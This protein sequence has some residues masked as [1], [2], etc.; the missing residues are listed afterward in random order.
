VGHSL[1]EC[2]TSDVFQNFQSHILII[3]NF[4]S[5]ILIIYNFDSY[6]Y[7]LLILVNGGIC[8]SR[9]AIELYQEKCNVN[10]V[11]PHNAVAS[12][13]LTDCHQVFFFNK[14]ALVY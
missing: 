7:N 11:I 14:I 8:K 2:A 9:D 6:S 3:Y 13:Y 12:D 10:S 5:H 1:H 4:Q